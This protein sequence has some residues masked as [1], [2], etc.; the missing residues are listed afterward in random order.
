LRKVDHDLR[1]L[2]V[3]EAAAKLIA[4]EGLGGLT[5]RALAKS[6]GCSIGVLSHYFNSKEEIVQ[7]AFNWADTRIDERME[8]ALGQNP[9]IDSFIPV[10]EAGLPLDESRDIEWRVRFNLYSQMLCTGDYIGQREKMLGFRTLLM[11]LLKEMKANGG[12]R[13]D[14]DPQI[15]AE[16]AFDLVIGAAQN[17]L[18]IPM[19]LREEYAANIFRIVENLRPKSA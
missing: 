2:E 15:I 12:I 10:I 6:M 18:M 7:A 4:R 9:T 19:E 13:Q 3:A 16:T 5:T 17:M 1:R 11:E 8:E 14:I